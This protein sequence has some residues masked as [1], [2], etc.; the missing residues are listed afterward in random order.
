LN[1]GTPYKITFTTL[2]VGGNFGGELRG[3][4]TGI[5]VNIGG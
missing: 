1:P 3:D 2:N 4:G 5:L